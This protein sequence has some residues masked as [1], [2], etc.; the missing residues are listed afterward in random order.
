MATLVLL[1]SSTHN[2]CYRLDDFSGEGGIDLPFSCLD[3]Q[4]FIYRCQKNKQSPKNMY[5]SSGPGPNLH[6][7]SCSPF[8]LFHLIS[9]THT[10][11]ISHPVVGS[12]VSCCIRTSLG[13]TRDS[14][15]FRFLFL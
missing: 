13:L 12:D 11:I 15:V 2:C 10:L 3:L 14:V 8:F 6:S 7:P 9:P 5:V 4:F 1:L